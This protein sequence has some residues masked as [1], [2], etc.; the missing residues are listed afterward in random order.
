MNFIRFSL[1]SFLLIAGH[2]ASAQVTTQNQY[3]DSLLVVLKTSPKD[4]TRIL[5]LEKI[6]HAYSTFNP[7]KGLEFAT[8]AHKLAVEL[9]LKN[10][11]ASS[12]AIMAL[13]HAGASNFEK[14]IE[15]NKNSIAIY[16]TIRN[17]KAIA[18]VNSN[19]S[20]IYLQLGKYSKAL[21]C[22]F[23]ALEIYDGYHENRNK[24]IVLENIA[25]IH[26]ELDNFAKASKYY[27]QALTLYKAFGTKTDIAR[28]LGNMSRVSMER[29]NYP[30]A[31]AHLNEALKINKESE[32][33][34]AI[35][36]NLTNIGNVY[37]KQN[38][39]EKALSFF[40]K[41]LKIS[42]ALS[43]KNFI[44][45][46]KGN[47]G[48]AYVNLYKQTDHADKTL[49]DNAITNLNEAIRLCDAIGYTAPKLEFSESLTEAFTLK[50]D[51]KKA[52]DLLQAKSVIRD[53]LQSLESKA[54]LTK[55][56][57]KR[58]NDLQLK[59][60][61]IKNKE[62]EIAKLNTQKKTLFHLLIIIIL[63]GMLMII[64]P[65]FIRKQKKHNK[66]LAEIKQMQSHEIRGPIATILGLAHILK[67]RTTEE[68]GKKELVEGIE[69]H[70]M[71][72][73][74]IVLRITKNTGK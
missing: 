7:T 42:E 17:K 13:N 68:T 4:S 63:T 70:A 74:E 46:N 73:D 45:I 71:K 61:I 3:I 47:I 48:G 21:E 49:L 54:E 30:A 5:A 58:E 23:A 59:N 38:L 11:E 15:F 41:S 9:R 67:H 40:R 62:L 37:S 36:V 14:A 44:A 24:G 10:R 34:S 27:N 57:I 55:L 43:L 28:C 12:I 6:G 16:K 18:A 39:N 60:I 29:K 33:K 66:V 65:Y 69:K 56:E 35:L 20:Q 50:K 22:N 1:A 51:Y 2:F 72:L 26:F 25:N 52:F 53:S 19:Q 32:N 8:K 31:L 64:I